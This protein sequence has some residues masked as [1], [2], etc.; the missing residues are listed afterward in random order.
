MRVLTLSTLFPDA[1]RPNFGI[2]V[3]RQT[4]GLAAHPD[5]ELRVVAPIGLPPW[6]LNRHAH[7]RA[8]ACVPREEV[9]RGLNILRPRFT[10]V[11]GTAGR[12][13]A[14]ALTAALRPILDRLRDTFVFDVID[15]SFFFPDGPPQSRLGSVTACRSRSRRAV[16]TS[17]TGVGHPPLRRRFV[18]Q[19]RRRTV[20]WRSVRR[21]ATTWRH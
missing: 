9:W 21:C 14:A 16:P 17:T 13:H 11:P 7:Y 6:P 12:F 8:L 4:S 10:T 18:A 19:D 3:E 1:T 15:A 20:F 2:F 5:V